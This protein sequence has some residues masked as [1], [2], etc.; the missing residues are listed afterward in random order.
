MSLCTRGP[1][2]EKTRRPH[3]PRNVTIRDEIA[4]VPKLQLANPKQPI[5]KRRPAKQQQPEELQQR[6]QLQQRRKLQWQV[7]RVQ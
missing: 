2:V 6:R 1:R 3:Q 4:A 5:Q 7:Q